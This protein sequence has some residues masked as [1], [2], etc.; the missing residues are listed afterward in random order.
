[1]VLEPGGKAG[2]VRGGPWGACDNNIEIFQYTKNLCASSGP[3]GL[4]QL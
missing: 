4:A 2:A 3:E 1:M